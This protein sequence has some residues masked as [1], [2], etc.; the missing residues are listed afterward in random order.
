MSAETVEQL[1]QDAISR[2]RRI[3]ESSN[4][5]EVR[6]QARMICYELERDEEDTTQMFDP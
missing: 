6:F 5:P 4:D 2:A 1:R 3:A